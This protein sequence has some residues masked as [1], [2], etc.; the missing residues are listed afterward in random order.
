M[1]TADG[2]VGNVV[3]LSGLNTNVYH[4]FR[5]KQVRLVQ[6]RIRLVSEQIA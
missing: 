3:R 4:A 5:V 6:K 2:G 1:Y